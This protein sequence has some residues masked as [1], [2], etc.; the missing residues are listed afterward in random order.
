MER[1]DKPKKSAKARSEVSSLSIGK[2]RNR[3]KLDALASGRP[4]CIAGRWFL[5]TGQLER[6]PV[7]GTS[8]NFPAQGRQ[9]NPGC[10]SSL[11]SLLPLIPLTRPVAQDREDG[12]RHAKVKH[13]LMLHSV[14]TRIMP[15][16]PARTVPSS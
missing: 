12:N 8:I 3:Q 5:L 13:L 4:V 2:A 6:R 1:W 15:R 14:G 9:G 10:P 7:Q 11:Y 16:M